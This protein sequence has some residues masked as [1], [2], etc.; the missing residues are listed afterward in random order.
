MAYGA[1]FWGFIGLWFLLRFQTK[2]TIQRFRW[3]IILAIAVGSFIIA[4][5][6]VTFCSGKQVPYV[7][8]P[9]RELGATC[10]QLWHSKF[11]D[12]CPYIAGDIYLIGLTAHAMP[13]RPSVIMPQGTWA[14][15][16]D[17]NCKGGMII[18]EIKDGEVDMPEYLRQRFPD[19][20]ALS[21][22]LELPY[23]VGRQSHVLRINIAIV[24][25]PD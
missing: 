16:D 17:L 3:A 14:N 21:E 22:T 5:W 1:P 23:K 12:N 18:W 11:P 6:L 2:E 13:V 7:Y 19:A 20:K 9:M 4:G 15:D 10:N 24:P 8:Y 25:P